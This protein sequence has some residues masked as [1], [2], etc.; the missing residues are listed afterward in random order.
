MIDYYFKILVITFIV[1]VNLILPLKVKSQEIDYINKPTNTHVI[2]ILPV[3]PATKTLYSDNTTFVACQLSQQLRKIPGIETLNVLNSIR[4]LKQNNTEKY[5][6]NLTQLYN[7]SELPDPDDLY[8]ITTTLN[9]DKLILVYGGFDTQQL[10]LHRSMKSYL[11]IFNP[12]VI[13]PMFDYNVYILMFDPTTGSIEWQKT[14]NKG[15][16]LKNFYLSTEN[17]GG[18]PVFLEE[19]QKFT[20]KVSADVV[21]NLWQY[22]Y[23]TEISTVKSQILK[24]SMESGKAREGD[25][26]TD[27]QP[28]LQQPPLPEN[29]QPTA[30]PESQPAKEP[31]SK[32]IQQEPQNETKSQADPIINESSSTKETANELNIKD[33]HDLS[34]I[35]PHY[36]KE[37][38][39]EYQKQMLKRY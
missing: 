26:T 11:N 37:L 38:L 18:S 14:Y 4:K 15:F 36:E 21:I 30:A 28:N 22:F 6:S 8:K 24:G 3:E 33:K 5:L 7:I 12:S 31:D 9:A 2:A 17:L 20:D 32:A 10:L 16:L 35:K 19:F 27:G 23:G 13:K 25:L 1:I 39:Q 34:D 29:V